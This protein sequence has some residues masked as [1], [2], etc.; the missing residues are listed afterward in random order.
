[1]I[2]ISS[3]FFAL[4]GLRAIDGRLPTDEEVDRGAPVAVVSERVAREYWPGQSP[5]GQTLSSKRATVTVIAVVRDARFQGLDE[6]ST[7]EIYVPAVLGVWTAS[8]PTYLV[9]A[10]IP[11]EAVLRSLIDAIR[12][13]DP[14]A[15]I[16]RAQDVEGALAQSIQRRRFQ[17]GLFGVMAVSG[18]V[19]A[20]AGILGVTAA[21]TARRTREMGVRL[22]LGSSRERLL[23]LLLREQLAP[24]VAGLAIGGLVAAW[25]VGFARSSLYELSA[26]D[27]SVWTTAI[28]V[29]LGVA[30]LGT[31]VPALRAARVDPVQALRV[32]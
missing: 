19:V 9:R 22:A 31:L 6:P 4:T 8:A 28:A 15:S 1:M 26:Y 11:D 20:G 16:R 3:G 13:F 2:P 5:L 30:V 25:A 21:S 14:A 12:A 29:V 17:A 7:G 24:V 10:T 23:G 32:E 18:L 27:P